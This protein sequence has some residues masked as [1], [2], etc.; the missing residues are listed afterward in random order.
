MK[1]ALLSISLF[2]SLSILF[3]ASAEK[4]TLAVTKVSATKA[5]ENA[6]VANGSIDTFKRVVE[7]LDVNLF[8]AF[9]NTRK[10]KMVS[11]TD[12]DAVMKEKGLAS[13]GNVNISD[14][15]AAKMGQLLGAKYIV[16][17]SVD[18][19]QDFKDKAR[20]EKLN[21]SDENRSIRIG[22]IAKVIDSTTGAILETAN[23]I[24]KKNSY[25]SKDDVATHS[26]GNKS[27]ENIALLARDISAQ[28]ANKVVDAI[29]P[30]KVIAKTGKVV[31]FNRGDG[32]GVNVGDEY[33]IFAVGDE[34][35]DPDTGDALGVEEVEI[36]KMRVT[37][38][39]PK[40]S[41]GELVVD[42]G[43]GKGQILRLTKKAEK[44][45]STADDNEI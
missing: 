4:S 45:Q 24:V 6:M 12:L 1:K 37:S 16:T 42:N 5:I 7:S 28:M 14:V 20:F 10:F 38:V 19:F 27:D 18:D 43:V 30:P 34:M 29:F 21:K 22:A 44:P 33:T 2:C 13:S 35:F 8:S 17:V 39:T 25:V 31:T 41:K 32:T 26:G 3:A 40:F 23:F 9:E 36:G 11:R 15:N